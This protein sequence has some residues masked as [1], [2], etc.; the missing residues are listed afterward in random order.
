MI[1]HDSV[2]FAPRTVPGLSHDFPS[3][4][5]K[6]PYQSLSALSA[7][8][9]TSGDLSVSS[10]P[11]ALNLAALYTA[12]RNPVQGRWEPHARQVNTQF[13]RISTAINPPF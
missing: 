6:N 8:L 5:L 2:S 11:Q 12:E 9:K 1:Q 4:K 13:R 10:S 7:Q 3:S